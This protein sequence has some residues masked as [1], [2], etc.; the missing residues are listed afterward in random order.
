MKKMGNVIGARKEL[1]KMDLLSQE[2]ILLL[3]IVEQKIKSQGNRKNKFL[4]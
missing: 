2:L 1:G 3:D 4:I